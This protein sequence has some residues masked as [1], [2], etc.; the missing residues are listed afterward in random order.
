[1]ETNT[2]RS[3]HR[4]F[5]AIIFAVFSI[6]CFGLALQVLV[7]QL[8]PGRVAGVTQRFTNDSYAKQ[9][10]VNENLIIVEAEDY[11]ANGAGIS[12]WDNTKGNSGN[13]Y[14]QDDVD[15]RQAAD[16][17]VIDNFTFGEWLVY[18][19]TPRSTGEYRISV[20]ND[21]GT[22]GRLSVELNKDSVGSVALVSTVI[23]L[24]VGVVELKGE[25]TYTLRIIAETGNLQLNKLVFTKLK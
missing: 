15:I 12:Y 22:S 3:Q 23:E 20:I 18:D 1:M 13:A 5:T 19:F 9:H 25:Q 4:P 10:F 8:Q 24:P 6:L 16:N 21:S 11:A 17:I 14:R 2:Q 7:D